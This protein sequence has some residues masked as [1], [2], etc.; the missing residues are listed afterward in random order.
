MAIQNPY[1]DDSVLGNAWEQGYLAG[2]TE[3]E[4]DHFRPFAPDLLQVYQ[5]GEQTGRDDRRSLPPPPDGGGIDE[6]GGHSDLAEVAKELGLHTLGHGFLEMIFKEAGGLISLVLTALTIPTDTPIEPLEEDWSGPADQP[7]DIYVAICP[8]EDHPL[9]MHGVTN[10]GY[11]AGQGHQF[12]SD[13]LADM[14]A[15]EHA[16]AFVARCSVPE[17]SCGAVWPGQGQ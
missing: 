14:Q 11:W 13:A 1:T 9:V 6:Q 4:V 7:D 10:E 2:F 15:H 17:G 12:F 3:P 5:E 8:R 16:E